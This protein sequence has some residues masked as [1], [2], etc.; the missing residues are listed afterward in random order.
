MEN[1]KKISKKKKRIAFKRPHDFWT[2][3][4]LSSFIFTIILLIA[5]DVNIEIKALFVAF[6]CITGMFLYYL[7]SSSKI[8]KV[9][10]KTLMFWKKKEHNVEE[11]SVAIEYETLIEM[12]E[13]KKKLEDGLKMIEGLES[14][15]KIGEFI[16]FM[17]DQN[18]NHNRIWKN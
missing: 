17:S 14:D 15:K 2:G 10:L 1:N 18:D 5:L 8:I 11:Y 6:L 13:S 3:F 12:I 7:D 9:S 4:A 16:R